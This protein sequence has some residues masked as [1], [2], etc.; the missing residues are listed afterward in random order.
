[1]HSPRSTGSRSLSSESSH[2]QSSRTRT[3]HDTSLLHQSAVNNAR[4]R[5]L[6][7]LPNSPELP[8]FKELPEDEDEQAEEDDL[9]EH[10]IHIPVPSSEDESD[11]ELE[12]AVYS[13][14]LTRLGICSTADEDIARTRGHQRGRDRRHKRAR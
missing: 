10:E 8:P 5:N 13:V 11:E 4:Q 3:R 2:R 9:S 14:R 1:M 7:S 12:D 6:W